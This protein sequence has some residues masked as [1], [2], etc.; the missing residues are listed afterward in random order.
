[1]RDLGRIE[2]I[3]AGAIGEP[4]HRTFY[5]ELR[6]D[7]GPEWFLIEKQQA[8]AL[9]ER[10]LE[11]AADMGISP[12]EP[13]PALESPGEPAFR[14]GQIALGRDGNDAV[15]ALS[16]TEDAGEDAEPVAATVAPEALDAMA[17]RTLLVVAAGRPPCEFC[18]NPKDPKGHTCPAS[19]GDLRHQ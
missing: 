14:V 17:R 4:G 9:A 1:M 11:L 18:G 5:I 8:A 7:A 3:L 6:S 2:E 19:N 16:P 15:I 12:Q 13:G 10:A